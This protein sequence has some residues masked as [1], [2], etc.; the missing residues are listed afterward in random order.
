MRY[1]SQPIILCRRTGLLW[2]MQR[3]GAQP[4][5]DVRGRLGLP[6]TPQKQFS[7]HAAGRLLFCGLFEF[8][9]LF[10]QPLFKGRD[11]F[12][13]ST[14]SSHGVPLKLPR[15]LLKTVP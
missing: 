7:G 12:D 13:A 10:R 3:W 1:A 15:L 11:V 14:T 5:A 9:R 4:I 8:D 2:R 6:G